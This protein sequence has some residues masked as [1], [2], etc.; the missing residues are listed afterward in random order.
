M[1]II[2][3]PCAN[4]YSLEWCQNRLTG[5][6]Q[7]SFDGYGRFSTDEPAHLRRLN[8]DHLKSLFS[9]TGIDIYKIYHRAHLFET[10]VR[11]GRTFRLLPFACV[12][13]G[14]LDW[15]LFKHFPNG[16]TMIALG[17]KG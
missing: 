4:K 15:H 11:K 17:K 2:S 3:T 8:D 10:I 7:P 13:F 16:S 9:Q 1:V 12:W 5:G 6:L 14:M